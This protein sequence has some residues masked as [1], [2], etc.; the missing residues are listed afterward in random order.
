MIDDDDFELSNLFCADVMIILTKKIRRICIEEGEK[1]ICLSIW[2]DKWESLMSRSTTLMY[3]AQKN[4]S[5]SLNCRIC[6]L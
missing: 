5:S 2:N 3:H 1:E 6:K 4:Y